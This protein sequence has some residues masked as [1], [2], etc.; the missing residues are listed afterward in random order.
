MYSVTVRDHVMIAHSLPRAVCGPA[1]QLHGAVAV[2]RR[3]TDRARAGLGAVALARL[4]GLQARH[5]QGGDERTAQ[6]HG[7]R[8]S[9]TDVAGRGIGMDVAEGYGGSPKLRHGIFPSAAD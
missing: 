8:P 2:A 7:H 3:A 1:Q 4:A 6:R 9:L 5:A